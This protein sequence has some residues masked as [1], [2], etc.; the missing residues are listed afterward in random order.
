ME[1][2]LKQKLIQQ[3]LKDIN[4][5]TGYNSGYTLKKDENESRI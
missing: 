5:S 1:K 2:Q 3:N 4:L